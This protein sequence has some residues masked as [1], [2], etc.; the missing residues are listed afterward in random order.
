MTEYTV[1]VRFTVHEHSD[2]LQSARAIQEEFESWL[3]GLK[4]TVHTVTVHQEGEE[5]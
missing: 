1:V 2:D 5:P 4:A 3:E